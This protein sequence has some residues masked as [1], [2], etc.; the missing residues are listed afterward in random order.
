MLAVLSNEHQQNYWAL[1]KG[2][3]VL[4][5]EAQNGA[6]DIER[7]AHLL[8]FYAVEVGLKFLL[9]YTM[10]L[11]YRH[12]VASRKDAHI[13][14]YSHDI[15]SMVT[16]LKISAARVPPA[17]APPFKCIN[18]YNHAGGGQSFSLPDVHTAWRY[19][20]TIDPTNEL[21]ILNYLR[22]LISY[23]NQEVPA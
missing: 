6:P 8:L 9:S 23:L 1:I 14:Q 5:R 17:P 16:D 3:D 21:D 19:G 18:G 13:E 10:K 4:E 7:F 20:L 12:E 15:E 2:S 11:P 22:K